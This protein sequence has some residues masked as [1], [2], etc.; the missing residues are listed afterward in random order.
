MAKALKSFNPL[1]PTV[2]Q[3][4]SMNSILR[5]AYTQ[6]EHLTI[7]AIAI[8]LGMSK[9]RLVSICEGMQAA[10]YL[11]LSNNRI[12]SSSSEYQRFMVAAGF[13][14]PAAHVKAKFAGLPVIT[15]PR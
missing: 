14:T 6:G 11:T 12:T 7:F 2:A 3:W 8:R 10:G 9:A 13:S 15:R 1:A 5:L 4:T